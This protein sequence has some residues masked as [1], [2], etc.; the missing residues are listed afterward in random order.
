MCVCACALGGGRRERVRKRGEVETP[1][2]WREKCE[3]EKG[4]R[5]RGRER[6]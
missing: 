1:R 2:E 5:E 6:K 3:G 4:E